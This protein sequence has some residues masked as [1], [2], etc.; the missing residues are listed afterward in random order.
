[1]KIRRLE[2][3]T[4][5]PRPLDEVFAFFADA[6]NLE[7]LTPPWL[8]FDIVTERPIEMAEGTLIDY[9]LRVRGLPLRWRS[10]ITVW[11]PPHRFVDEQRKGPY[12]LWRHEHL[13]EADGDDATRV[14]DRVDYAVWLDSIVH[15]FVRRDVENIFDYRQERLVELLGLTP[16]GTP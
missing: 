4:R 1:M 10:E 15:P 3:S 5:L 9:R 14:T 8:A 11:D 13:F 6:S 7:E 12:R 2:R 16:P